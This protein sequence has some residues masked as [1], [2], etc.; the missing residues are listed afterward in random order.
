[1]TDFQMLANHDT[2]GLSAGYGIDVKDPICT[3]DSPAPDPSGMI[4]R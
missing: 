4:D 1:M 2:A 3:D